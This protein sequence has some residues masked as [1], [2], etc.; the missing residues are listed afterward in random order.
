MRPALT[1]VKNKRLNI[2]FKN[3]KAG[4]HSKGRIEFKKILQSILRIFA[5]LN[6]L[7]RDVIAL[8]DAHLPK[9]FLTGTIEDIEMTQR[10][11]LGAS[12]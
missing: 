2:G 5:I 7:Y 1:F 11:L 4:F 3:S 8:M 9:E 12:I 10:F 6:Y